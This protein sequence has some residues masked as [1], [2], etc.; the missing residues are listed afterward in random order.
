MNE[1]KEMNGAK[2]TMP[3]AMYQV[4]FMEKH[5]SQAMISRMDRCKGSTWWREVWPSR[6][7]SSN[8]HVSCDVFRFLA[9]IQ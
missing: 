3:V 5:A 2:T 8:N 4:S 9:T 7:S 1:T 6:L